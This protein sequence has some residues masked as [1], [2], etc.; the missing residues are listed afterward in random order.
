MLPFIVSLFQAIAGLFSSAALLDLLKVIFGSAA[1]L[2]LM[3]V[4]IGCQPD[5]EPIE[6]T[7]SAGFDVVNKALDK[8]ISETTTRT[9]TMQGNLTG[10]EPGWVV[11]GYG[12][13]G[14]GVVYEGQV[15]A[16]G[17]S[18]TLQGHTQTDSGEAITDTRPAGDRTP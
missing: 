6:R 8:A 7:A 17:V 9:A 12:I 15:F 1:C 16:K 2:G 18:G 5:M 14:T 11:R 10:V 3:C 4:A 13:F